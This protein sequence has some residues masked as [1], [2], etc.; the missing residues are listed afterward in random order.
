MI[1]ADIVLFLAQLVAA[2]SLGFTGGYVLTKFRDAM[3]LTV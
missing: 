1:A 2:W 3:N